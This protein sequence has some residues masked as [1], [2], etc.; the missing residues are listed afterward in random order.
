[1]NTAE[2]GA[3]VGQERDVLR[4]LYEL[5]FEPEEI[6][7]VRLGFKSND[8]FIRKE[9]DSLKRKIMSAKRNGNEYQSF[10]SKLLEISSKIKVKDQS[11]SKRSVVSSQTLLVY[12][13]GH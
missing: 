7:E 3:P 5:G 9:M 13:K 4:L 2:I 1:M 11:E 6:N 10:L 12:T 8:L